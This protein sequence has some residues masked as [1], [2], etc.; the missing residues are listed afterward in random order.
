MVYDHEPAKTYSLHVLSIAVTLQ[1]VHIQR[2]GVKNGGCIR[3]G[4]GKHIHVRL[5]DTHRSLQSCLWRVV[6]QETHEG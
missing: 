1:L 5:Q 4:L 2:G 6:T 3:K